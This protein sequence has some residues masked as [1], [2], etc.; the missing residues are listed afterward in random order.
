M[1]DEKRLVN[2]KKITERVAEFSG[3][4]LEKL[5]YVKEFGNMVLRVII[6]KEEGVSTKDC[7]IVSRALS[8]KLDELDLIK[9]HYYLEVASPGVEENVD[10]EAI[11]TE[12]PKR[13]GTER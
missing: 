13:E 12:N 1:I 4:N 6:S 7:E 3:V 11:Q 5:E 10:V 2:I 8:K 9:E